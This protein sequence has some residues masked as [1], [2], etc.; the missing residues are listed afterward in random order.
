MWMRF[1]LVSLIIA[2]KTGNAREGPRYFSIR[3]RNYLP[4]QI[5]TI[6]H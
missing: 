4:F 6:N 2:K 5:Q 1:E 3:N